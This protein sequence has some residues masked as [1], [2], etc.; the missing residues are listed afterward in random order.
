MATKLSTC[1]L[2]HGCYGG[3]NCKRLNVRYYPLPSY[4]LLPASYKKRQRNFSS[5]QKRQQTK[6]IIPER[7]PTSANFQ[8]N[9]DEDSDSENSSIDSMPSLNQATRFINNVDGIGA[10]EHSNRE[11]LNSLM[12]PIEITSSVYSN[13]YYSLRFIYA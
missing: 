8:S 10:V 12:L 11:D 6:K 5:Q 13:N 9:D 2:N 7:N 4:R 1:F 3:L